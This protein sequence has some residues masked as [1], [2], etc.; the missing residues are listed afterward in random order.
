M[1]KVNG[2]DYISSASN[3]LS[4]SLD[5]AKSY[6]VSGDLIGHIEIGTAAE[7]AGPTKLRLKGV[8]ILSDA[9]SGIA[10]LP[11]KKKLTVEV[12]ANTSNYIRVENGAEKDDAAAIISNSDLTITGAGFLSLYANLG[13]G[14]KA[15]ELTVN[16]LPKLKIDAAHDAFH[17]SKLLRITGG[18][19]TIDNCN[20]AFSAGSA[21]SPSKITVEMTIT[22]GN[23]VINR[24][25]DSLFQN[26][27]TAG[28]CR[29]IKGNFTV[30]S[31]NVKGLF[32]EE[33]GGSKIVVYDL[34][35]WTGLSTEQL[36]EVNERT[37]ILAD[38]Y[39]ECKV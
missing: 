16:G 2:A 3:P 14:L 5:A 19:I 28:N 20:D 24:V 10:Y 23:F 17:A 15:S 35:S 29:I 6:D 27:S 18:D 33:A 25:N 39:S 12:F 32:Q 30:S 26:K 7:P 34:C 9:D 8:N 36:A 13:H 38:Q 37:L 1:L 22:D 21:D 11:E 31:D 4:I